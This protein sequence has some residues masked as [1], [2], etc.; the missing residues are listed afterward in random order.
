MNLK[1]GGKK[2]YAGW[3]ESANRRRETVWKLVLSYKQ[4]GEKLYT[5]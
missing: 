5:G 4:A 2:V 1:A 3:Y